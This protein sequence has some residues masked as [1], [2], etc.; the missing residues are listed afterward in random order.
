MTEREA[1]R[2]LHSMRVYCTPAHL[3]AVDYA[4]QLLREKEHARAEK[5]REQAKKCSC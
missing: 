4:I 2:A 5:G 1:I 3:A